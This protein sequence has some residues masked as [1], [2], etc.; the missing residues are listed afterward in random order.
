MTKEEKIRLYERIEDIFCGDEDKFEKLVEEKNYYLVIGSQHYQ[1][2]RIKLD[3]KT[4][5]EIDN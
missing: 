4:L 1:D 5:E 3:K 2:V